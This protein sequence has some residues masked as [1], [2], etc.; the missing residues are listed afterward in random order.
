MVLNHLWEALGGGGSPVLA[1]GH[2]KPAEDLGREAGEYAE[3]ARRWEEDQ[4]GGAIPDQAR[5]CGRGGVAALL[6]SRGGGLSPTLAVVLGV[7]T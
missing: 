3:P 4:A 1:T 6:R 7:R 2:E 5:Q